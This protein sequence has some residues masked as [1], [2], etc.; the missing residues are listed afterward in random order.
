IDHETSAVMLAATAQMPQDQ[1]IAATGLFQCIGQHSEPG[2]VQRSCREGAILEDR[3]GETKHRGVIPGEPS[4]G[5]SHGT[6]GITEEIPEQTAL[7]DPL[8][9]QCGLVQGGFAVWR[10]PVSDR[11]GG[12]V[13]SSQ[14]S[15]TALAITSGKCVDPSLE[16]TR[17]GAG[18]ENRSK[19]LK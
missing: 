8:R 16:R 5:K 14:D 1:L 15:V 9:C 4:R 17:R 19:R 18:R 12:G 7:L 2:I 11:F 6:E 3:L 10:G 13:H